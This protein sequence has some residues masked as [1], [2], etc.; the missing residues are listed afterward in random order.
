MIDFVEHYTYTWVIISVISH[1]TIC[2]LILCPDDLYGCTL[3]ITNVSL[4]NF[5][6]VVIAEASS[7]VS[8]G[9]F[10]E[11]S[12]HCS[13]KQQHCTIAEFIWSPRFL[14]YSSLVGTGEWLL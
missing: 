12:G 14:Y 4:Y 3:Q 6:G 7:E 9:S 5:T 8:V 10:H 1:L 11:L 13:Y 2:G